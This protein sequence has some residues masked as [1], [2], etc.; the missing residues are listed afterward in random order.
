MYFLNPFYVSISMNHTNEFLVSTTHRTVFYQFGHML[1]MD[2]PLVTFLFIPSWCLVKAA[3]ERMFLIW[4]IV[5]VCSVHGECFWADGVRSR[6][7]PQHHMW[8]GLLLCK[9]QHERTQRN[10]SKAFSP[11]P[12]PRTFPQ[13]ANSCRKAPIPAPNA[14]CYKS[15]GDYSADMAR[16]LII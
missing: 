12:S 2:F 10:K 9:N 4:L 14:S 3:Q 8:W 5:L 11:L 16:A 7:S 6:I 1:L 13:K 15:Q